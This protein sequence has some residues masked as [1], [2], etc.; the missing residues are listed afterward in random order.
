[1]NFS[2]IKSENKSLWFDFKVYNTEFFYSSFR[3]EEGECSK[4]N[5]GWILVKYLKY[6]ISMFSAVNCSG[7]WIVFFQLIVDSL[8]CLPFLGDT[9]GEQG[10][11]IFLFGLGSLLPFRSTTFIYS[12]FFYVYFLSDTSGVLNLTFSSTSSIFLDYCF[13]FFFIFFL[14]SKLSL[15]SANELNFPAGFHNLVLFFLAV[16][17]ESKFPWGFSWVGCTAGVFSIAADFILVML[18]S[19]KMLSSLLN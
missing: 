15:N 10:K 18:M 5:I 14:L 4:L 6:I 3:E 1:M 17:R 12:F 19:S 11:T 8:M 13:Y 9:K 16:S 7:V 2:L